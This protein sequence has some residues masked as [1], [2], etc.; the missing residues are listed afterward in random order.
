MVSGWKPFSSR[1]ETLLITVFN[2]LLIYKSVL[3][4]GFI[5]VYGVFK[6]VIS[7]TGNF[8]INGKRMLFFMGLEFM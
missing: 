2:V 3:F 6:I 7:L 8:V 5:G 4:I 1:V